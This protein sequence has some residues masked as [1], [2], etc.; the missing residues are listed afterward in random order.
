LFNISIINRELD[1]FDEFTARDEY[2]TVPRNHDYLTASR[3]QMYIADTESAVETDIDS[4]TAF[5]I[6]RKGSSTGQMR[7]QAW[8]SGSG[9]GSGISRTSR[10]LRG[11][12]S[13]SAT[14]KLPL[15]EIPER[16]LQG[17]LYSRFESDRR[18]GSG[19]GSAGITGRLCIEE[20]RSIW[21][22]MGLGDIRNVK[23][24][25][26]SQAYGVRIDST[27][28]SGTRDRSRL[29]P[30]PI[31]IPISGLE[32][33]SRSGHVDTATTGTQNSP[34]PAN[35]EPKNGLLSYSNRSVGSSLQID[36]NAENAL[37]DTSCEVL[38]GSSN[39]NSDK[40][41]I[42]GWSL[43]YS[44]D[45]RPCGRLISLGRGATVLIHEATFEDGKEAEAVAKRHSTVSEA[46][47]V[48]RE[49][50]VQRLILTHFSQRYPSAPPTPK[51]GWAGAVLAFDFM[52]LTFRDLLWAPALTPILCEVFPPPQSSVDE[53][54]DEDGDGGYVDVVA[55][56]DKD[57]A[58]AGKT[59]GNTRG[60]S[61]PL[62]NHGPGIS[63]KASKVISSTSFSS[64][65][66]NLTRGRVLENW[67]DG[68]NSKRAKVFVEM[69]EA[70]T[71][72]ETKIR[73]ETGDSCCPPVAGTPSNFFPW[74]I[75]PMICRE[76]EKNV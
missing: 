61:N 67:T 62:V 70:E 3:S 72:A 19:G 37:F 56:V 74:T 33:G 20:A 38:D 29:I 27:S 36:N 42:D 13:G 2:W 34:D 26:C 58:V 55:V 24:Q 5:L 54:G 7:S 75:D 23:V 57:R 76:V 22:S 18:S 25:H 6:D 31:P 9:S 8:S 1:E 32:S 65:S 46:L 16:Y 39:S 45:T 14:S 43:V 21:S 66:P 10:P 17:A 73:V 47:A 69:A 50:S 53:D 35:K 60:T 11:A 40:E 4:G 52:E 64:S 30:K 71:E 28:A 12:G 51:L 59:F 68:N 63:A 49:M 48:S 41:G 44:G 15:S